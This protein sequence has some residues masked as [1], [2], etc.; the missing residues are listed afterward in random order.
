MGQ[1]TKIAWC[2]HTFNPWM[3]CRRVSPACE[4]CYAEWFV[5]HRMG[6]R[7]WGSNPR[8]RTTGP[9]KDIRT[10][11]RDAEAAGE[12]RRVFCGS[13]MDIFEDYPQLEPW[14]Q[15][16][17]PVI[18][19]SPWLFFLLLTKRPENIPRM[20]PPDLQ[21]AANVGLGT[22]V[23]SNEF[24]GRLD[25][26]CNV[27]AVVHFVSCEPQLEAI[28]FRPWL[29][30]GL[31]PY[32]VNWIITGGESKQGKDH[33]PRPYHLDWPLQIVEHGREYGVP[34]FVKQ[35]GSN[36]IGAQGWQQ[37]ACDAIKHSKGEKLEEWP[38]CLQ[39]QRVPAASQRK[40]KRPRR[41]DLT[42]SAPAV[43]ALPR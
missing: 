15:E 10:W 22:T 42:S 40:P 43:Q 32:R 8:L 31:V 23:E 26:L 9:W 3:G 12:I 19:Q 34:V 37:T 7:V 38:K 33:D 20:L 11:N 39:V 13:L 25:H 27:P 24:L 41:R 4:H 5:T 29:S 28:D 14:R 30:D 18:R 17:W 6:K 35:L 21:G 36:P 16:V 2:D 1:V